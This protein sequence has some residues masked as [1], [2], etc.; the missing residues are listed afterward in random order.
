MS[1]RDLPKLEFRVPISPN[2]KYMRMLQYF[3]ESL[4]VFAGPVARAAHCVVSVSPEVKQFDIYEAYPW[5]RNHSIDFQ[6][7]DVDSFKKFSYFATGFHRLT[8]KSDADIVVLIDA[9][10]LV[11]GNFDSVIIQSYR[12]QRVLGFIAHVSPFENLP[13]QPEASSEWYWQRVFEEA[14]LPRPKLEF[15]HTGWG[16]MSTKPLYRYCPAYFNFG[17][18]IAPRVSVD[19]MGLTYTEEIAAVD[20]VVDIW[21]KSQIANTLV[22]ARHNISVGAL[23]INYNF[24]LHVDNEQIRRLNPDPDGLNSSEDIKIFHYLGDGEVNKDHFSTEESLNEVLRREKMSEPG[25]VFLRKLK[26]VHEKVCSDK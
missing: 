25:A 6:W 1:Q 18:I 16:L 11:T 20:R 9:D 3:M 13:D 2:E 24:P 19:L 8:V 17:F 7:V 15:E 14:D 21:F 12:E 22:F 26:L 4:Q 23:P 10:L 5:T